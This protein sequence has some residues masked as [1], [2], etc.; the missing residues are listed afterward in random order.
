M[1]RAKGEKLGRQAVNIDQAKEK[2]SR[3]KSDWIE[4]S[5][6]IE[7]ESD[8]RFQMIDIILTDILGWGYSEIKT[9][10]KGES[11][12]VDYLMKCGG[13]NFLVIEAKRK[14]I[15]LIATQNPQKASYK[16]GGAAFKIAT[17][18]LSQARGYCVDQSVPFAG[19]TNG[20]QW[21]GFL[22]L[23]TDG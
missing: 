16:I 9:E 2:F 22:A 20:F 10:K 4:R 6:Q 7:T 18:G 15:E 8:A 1:P 19:L 11:G 14:G 17:D 21:V 3:H 12:F 13:R 23:R 5:A